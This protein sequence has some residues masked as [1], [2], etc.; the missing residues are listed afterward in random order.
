MVALPLL[1]YAKTAESYA[2]YRA[3]KKEFGGMLMEVWEK[4]QKAL[5]YGDKSNANVDSLIISSKQSL[6]RGYV[7][8]E[9]YKHNFL[10][11][12]EQEA[13]N[14]G[15]I[16]IHDLDQ[17]LYPQINCCLFDVGNVMKG[18]FEMANTK[19]TEPQSLRTALQLISDIVL[20]ASSQQF[21]GFTV[22]ELDK[23]LVPYYEKSFKRHLDDAH[24]WGI[25]GAQLYALEKTE[26]E[27]KQGL[28]AF[29][30]K[31]N[32]IPS[33]RGDFAF[34]TVTFGLLDNPETAE[35]QKRI[36][37]AI[38]EDRM[39]PAV[40]PVFPKLVYLY[41]EETNHE[42]LFDLAIECSCKCL[43]PDFLSL[44]GEGYVADMYRKHGKAVSPMGCRAFLSEGCGSFIGRANIGAVSLNLPM[45]YMQEGDFYAN[46]AHYL[47]MIRLL[48]IKRY[49]YVAKAPCSTN[50]LAFTQ[51][52]LMGGTKRPEEP[53]GDI[54]KQFTASFG[55]TALNEL[56]VL[57]EGK[58]LHESDQTFITEVVDFIN[59]VIT[60]FRDE[61]GYLYA[62]YG[63]PAESLCGTQVQQFRNKYG[64]IK[65]VSDREYF[66]NSFH[67]HVSAPINPFT[68]QDLEANLYHSVNGGHIQYTRL[69]T[70]KPNV[71]KGVILR[72]M[73][74]GFY[75][76]VNAN[77]C[78]C[79]DCGHSTNK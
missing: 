61:D 36:A 76:G 26:D 25:K 69:D 42:D 41:N 14:N 17:L 39:A 77:K 40:P 53:I 58:P 67:M 46:L 52:G 71:V 35:I 29:S 34:T 47:L 55:I 22:P 19:Y 63:T 4:T 37:I 75:S 74:M 64:I 43:Y 31:T 15:Y 54:V 5:A 27:L 44:S 68:K 11:Q 23:V 18:G 12:E 78:F 79:Q 56:N 49:E 9:L 24:R 66:T 1:G 50:P 2:Q 70:D 28:Q 10:T 3:Y 16:Y 45:I 13:I 33:S 8:K 57:H 62:L 21:G 48:L 32:T 72:G 7:S 30:L 65:G 51:G 38:L 73:M 20:C 6:V 59:K 60:K